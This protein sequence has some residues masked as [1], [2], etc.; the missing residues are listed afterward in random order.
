M[1]KVLSLL[2]LLI[3]FMV[4]AQPSVIISDGSTIR[5]H[6]GAVMHVMSDNPNS[7]VKYGTSGGIN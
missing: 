4:S 2:F 6:G 1:H 5:I 7:I 3:P